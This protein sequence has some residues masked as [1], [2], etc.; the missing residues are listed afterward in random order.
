MI[1]TTMFEFQLLHEDPTGARAGRITTDRGVI[2]TPAFMPVATQGAVKALT[3]AEMRELGAQVLLAN[4]Y[5]LYLRPGV[6]VIAGAGGLQAFM[7]WDGPVLTDSGGYQI[8][9]QAPLIAISEEGVEFRSH[10]DGAAH[11][12]TP[13]AA[14]ELQERLGADIV[15]ALDQPVGYPTDAAAAEEA[16]DRSDRWA[17]RCQKASTGRGALFGIVQGGFDSALRRRSAARLVDLGLPGYAVG[18]L[19]VGEDKDTTFALLATVV[20]ELPRESP[21]YLMGMGLPA[22]LA[23]AVGEGADLFDCVLPT[24]FGR[25]AAAVTSRGRLNLRNACYDRDYGPLDP[26]CACPTCR[27][28]SRAYLRHLVQAREIGAARLLTYHNVHFYLRLMEDMRDAILADRFGEWA[29]ER[30]ARERSGAA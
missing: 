27:Q 17:G 22:D 28:H 12:L 11:F 16:T 14:V 3:A 8:F 6:E 15:M 1:A 26:E 7:G 30:E 5:H 23:R 29:D 20:A 19:S 25:T 4:A 2:E 24:R 13:E 18:G 9:S 21:R 10:L